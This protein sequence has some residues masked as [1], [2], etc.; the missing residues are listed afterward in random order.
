MEIEFHVIWI[1]Q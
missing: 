1:I